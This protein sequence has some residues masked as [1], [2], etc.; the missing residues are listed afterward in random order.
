M[1]CEAAQLYGVHPTVLRL[2]ELLCISADLSWYVE[3]GIITRSEFF[4]SIANAYDAVFP[5]LLGLLKDRETNPYIT[6]PIM[7][8]ESWAAFMR[9]LSSFEFQGHHS[10]SSSKL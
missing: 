5:I 8:S 9:G 2:Y 10:T 4:K 7:A 6:A 3:N 1:A